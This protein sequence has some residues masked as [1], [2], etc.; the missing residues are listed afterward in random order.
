[1]T[2]VR[3]FMLPLSERK[4]RIWPGGEGGEKRRELLNGCTESSASLSGSLQFFRT[5]VIQNML[6]IRTKRTILVETKSSKQ[7]HHW[8][9][10]L[11][12]LL[13]RNAR[14]VLFFFFKEGVVFA[15]L[16]HFGF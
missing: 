11:F 6:F 16:E 3:G 2:I 4:R 13:L 7:W 1:M 10:R 5:V 14:M 12:P 8:I 9:K 15:L